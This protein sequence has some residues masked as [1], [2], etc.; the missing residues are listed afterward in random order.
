MKGGVGRG[1]SGV[2]INAKLKWQAIL[3]STYLAF[4]LEAGENLRLVLQLD[5]F[6]LIR[7]GLPDACERELELR[8]MMCLCG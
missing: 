6:S 4:A 8:L 2:G 3:E 7:A 5:F 1:A